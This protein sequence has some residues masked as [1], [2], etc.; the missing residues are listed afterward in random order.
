MGFDAAKSPSLVATIV[1]KDPFTAFSNSKGAVCSHWE[2]EYTIWAPL[3][4]KKPNVENCIT[5]DMHMPLQVFQ[6]CYI[7]NWFTSWHLVI[8]F[9]LLRICPSQEENATNLTAPA[10][11]GKSLFAAEKHVIHTYLFSCACSEAGAFEQDT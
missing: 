9:L 1:T 8:L 7:S 3:P 4:R 2:A 6:H 5:K 10:S 11:F